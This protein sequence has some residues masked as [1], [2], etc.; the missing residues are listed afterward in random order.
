MED[1]Y[2]L[3]QKAKR[4]MENS[5]F[6]EAI[7]LLE[8]AKGL[9]AGKGSI[10]EALAISYY[11]SGLF[12]PAK[13]NFIA[14]LDIDAANDFA[15]YGLGLCLLKEGDINKALGYLKI[16][17]SMKPDSRLYQKILKKIKGTIL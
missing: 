13:M 11:N 4:F 6:L 17:S 10:R 12:R 2:D 3:F 1:A 5:N 15:H 8:K 14:A 16:A 9:E 7:M